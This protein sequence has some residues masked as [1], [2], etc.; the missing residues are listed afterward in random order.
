MHAYWF[1]KFHIVH[2]YFCMTLL[3]RWKLS[4]CL[5]LR[6]TWQNAQSRM[7]KY[8]GLSMKKYKSQNSYSS[9]YFYFNY[10]Q[11]IIMISIN[12]NKNKLTI[13]VLNKRNVMLLRY[14]K[15]KCSSTFL[16]D[17]PN[18]NIVDLRK[19]I[20]ICQHL[21]R[22]KSNLNTNFFHKYTN[23]VSTHIYTLIQH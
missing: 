23:K 20:H 15:N 8:F 2:F 16:R 4:Y 21:L 10:K 1:R 11:N 3:K 13:N 18:I 5:I 7:Q 17:K 19:D 14:M 6:K 9:L 12:I 22:L